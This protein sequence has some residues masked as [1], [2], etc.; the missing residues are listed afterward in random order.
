[1]F[2]PF[3]LIFASLLI[4]FASDRLIEVFIGSIGFSLLIVILG[5]AGTNP[6]VGAA[7]KRNRD[8]GQS[9]FLSCLR[10]FVQSSIF[11]I[12]PNSY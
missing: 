5:F 12:S 4:G 7:I 1:M 2:G 9:I 3:D 11:S 6:Y 8:D 10:P